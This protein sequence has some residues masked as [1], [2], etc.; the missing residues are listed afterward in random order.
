MTLRDL[1]KVDWRWHYR[2]GDDRTNDGSV[3]AMPHEGHAYC[4]CKA[5]RLSS[6]KSWRQTAAM[7]SRLPQLYRTLQA[8]RKLTDCESAD[9]DKVTAAVYDLATAEVH[10]LDR[11]LGHD[12]GDS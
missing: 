2:Q 4:I 10:Y 9:P 1:M 11:V 6:A 3:Y 8:I 7:L 12:P 5:P